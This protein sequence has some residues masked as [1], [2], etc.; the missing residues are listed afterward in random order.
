[1]NN[2]AATVT[3][4]DLFSNNFKVLLLHF[5]SDIENPDIWIVLS[6][7]ISMT[8]ISVVS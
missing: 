8:K 1:M 6:V 7:K 2:M 3:K 4:I 5:L